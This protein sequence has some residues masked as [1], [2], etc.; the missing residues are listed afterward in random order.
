M[1]WA[2]PANPPA[3]PFDQFAWLRQELYTLREDRLA[4]RTNATALIL[5]HIPPGYDSFHFTPL[6][7]ECYSEKYLSITTE[8]AEVIG[9]QL[10]AHQHVDTFRLTPEISKHGSAPPPLFIAG[11][12]SPLYAN[13]PSFRKWRY[14]D[15]K[16]LDYS[17]ISADLEAMPDRQTSDSIVTAGHLFREQYSARSF[18]ELDS[19]SAT[20]WRSKVANRLLSSDALWSRFVA[21]LYS[22]FKDEGPF[23][24]HILTDA[25][26]RA[27]SYCAISNLLKDDF[28]SCL[29]SLV[30]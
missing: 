10:F 27:K 1:G 20:E 3:D 9:G 18:F 25:K 21:S 16:L 8:F 22:R 12:M 29:N 5:G 23:Q 28:E 7:L 11:A 26:F 15:G 14:K 17:L 2:S 4:G 13:N 24:H 30:L 19:L 6:W